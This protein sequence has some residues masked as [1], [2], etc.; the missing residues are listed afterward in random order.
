MDR[1]GN[2]SI[3][4]RELDCE[5]FRSILRSVISPGV[6]HG[7]MG[8]ANYERSE[9]N[10]NSMIHLCLRKA[11]LNR[12]TALSFEEFKAF[13]LALRQE[14]GSVD[15]A[16]LVFAL[17]DLDNDGRIDEGEF[18]EIFRFFLGH[19]PS[20]AEF[21]A[22]WG[23]LDVAGR[24]RVNRH[25][26]FRWLH[27]S[28]HPIFRR[29]VSHLPSPDGP[30]GVGDGQGASRPTTGLAR[31]PWNPRFNAQKNGNDE[32]PAIR[33]AY[34]S[35]PQSLPELSRHFERHRGFKAQREKLSQPAEPKKIKVLSTDTASFFA[36]NPATGVPG[37]T[38]RS[39]SGQVVQWKDHWQTPLCVRKPHK[40]GTHLLRCPGQPPDW[41][42]AGEGET[43]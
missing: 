40:P 21:Q 8:G 13:T 18:R 38:M 33:R 29:L 7:S 10:M 36:F 14:Q 25:E 28:P 22:E 6:N 15:I 32:M 1:D 37:G 11:D 27:T 31:P 23:H 26:Y 17:F 24:T 4:R 20:E 5:E 34:L 43:M 16:N 9:M 3:S 39:R 30:S 41:M 35:R 12:D 19:N 2:E 42:F